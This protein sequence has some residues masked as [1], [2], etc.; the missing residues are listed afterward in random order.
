M[1]FLTP[2]EIIMIFATVWAVA[3]LRRDPETFSRDLR[4]VTRYVHD[5]IKILIYSEH[6]EKHKVP[7]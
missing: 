1:R 5:F 2:D 4:I 3:C 6:R 7:I